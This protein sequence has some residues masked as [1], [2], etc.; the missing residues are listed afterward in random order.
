VPLSLPSSFFTNVNINNAEEIKKVTVPF[1]WFH[2]SNDEYLSL[3][4]HGQ[5]VYD[6][7]RGPYKE[8]HIVQGA[9]HNNVPSVMGYEKYLLDLGKFIRR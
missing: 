3:S 4:V 5:K 8:A 6:N 1:C 9:V 2:G 7:Y